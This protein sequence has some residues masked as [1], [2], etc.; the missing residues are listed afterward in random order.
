MPTILS[1]LRVDPFLANPKLSLNMLGTDESG[2]KTAIDIVL[3][4]NTCN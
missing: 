3:F 4:C 1:G 2:M